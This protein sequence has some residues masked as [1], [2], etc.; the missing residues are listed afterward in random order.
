LNIFELKENKRV[1]QTIRD[2][3]NVPV[4]EDFASFL[5]K[6]GNGELE[7]DENDF[8]EI[9]D[10][11]I[12]H[13]G[14]DDAIFGEF[15]IKEHMTNEDFKNMAKRVILTTINE[16]AQELIKSWRNYQIKT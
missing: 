4:Q 3:D 15:F 8:V 11:C 1:R 14:L 12:I 13:E 16:K 5:L 2:D 7:A 9:S 6:M 10:N